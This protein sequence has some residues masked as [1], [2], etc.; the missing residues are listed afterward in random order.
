MIKNIIPSNIEIAQKANMQ[1]I[2][3]IAKQRLGIHQDD[4]GN[5]SRYKAKISFS[6]LD[7]LKNKEDGKL[8]F[9]TVISPTPAEEGK[10]TITVGLSDALNCIGKN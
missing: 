3:N 4:L 6:F 9:V 5:Y 10:T 1:K 8:I 7:K 2:S